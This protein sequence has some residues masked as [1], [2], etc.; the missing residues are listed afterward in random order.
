MEEKERRKWRRLV[1]D[2]VLA[3]G[4]DPGV[5]GSVLWLRGLRVRPNLLE[6][7]KWY[8]L[9]DI[10]DIGGDRPTARPTAIAQLGWLAAYNTM[11]RTVP[12]SVMT[13]IA[14]LIVGQEFRPM[15]AKVFVASWS[16]YALEEGFASRVWHALEHDKLFD[17]DFPE[18]VVDGEWDEDIAP[19]YEVN[20]TAVNAAIH[21]TV[22]HAVKDG[23]LPILDVLHAHGFDD[24]SL[25]S[26][27]GDVSGERVAE[28]LRACQ[29]LGMRHGRDLLVRYDAQCRSEAEEYAIDW[30]RE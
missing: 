23:V 3:R 14:D 21:L 11:S 1:G 2:I 4:Y 28:V 30:W 10:P 7:K 9:E 27:S 22:D 17:A 24:S 15:D 29:K 18:Y 16:V 5:I 13:D 6:T 19:L 20:D 8:R 25:G 12:E 26:D